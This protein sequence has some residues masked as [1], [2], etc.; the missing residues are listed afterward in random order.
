MTLLERMPEKLKQ[1][2]EKK[3]K[4]EVKEVTPSMRF[5]QRLNERHPGLAEKLNLSCSSSKGELQRR[6]KKHLESI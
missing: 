6:V 1:K 2:V 3:V 5:L 4:V